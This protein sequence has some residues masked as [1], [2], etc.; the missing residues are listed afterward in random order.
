M[1]STG[2]WR[3]QEDAGEFVRLATA[4]DGCVA[5]NPSQW[6]RV[7]DKSATMLHKRKTQVQHPPSRE[8]DAVESDKMLPPLS[9]KQY[10]N[11]PDMVKDILKEVEV[12]EENGSGQVGNNAAQEEDTSAT[13]TVKR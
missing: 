10:L 9:L 11:Q 1:E 6:R 13:S 7:L 12:R 2:T 3:G 5:Y 8:E 4:L